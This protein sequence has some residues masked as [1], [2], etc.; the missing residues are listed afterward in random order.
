MKL[1]GKDVDE[2]T[3]EI[4]NVGALDG[5]EYDEDGNETEESAGV[6]QVQSAKF[7]DGSELSEEELEEL[8]EEEYER[9]EELAEKKGL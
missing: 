6:Y 4:E 2:S 1:N 3:L 8:N 7:T 5:E 9:I